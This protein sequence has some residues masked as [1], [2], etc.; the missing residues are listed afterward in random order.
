VLLDFGRVG[1]GGMGVLDWIWRSPAWAE[2]ALEEG[3]DEWKVYRG[4]L[5]LGFELRYPSTW[6]PTKKL[7]KTHSYELNLTGPSSNFVGLVVDPVK[8][9]SVEEFGTIQEVAERVLGLE[10]KKDG[11]TSAEL[12][13]TEVRVQNN[14]SGNPELSYYVLDYKVD[15]SRGKKRF[16]SVATITGQQLFVLTAQAKDNDYDSSSAVLHRIIDSFHVKKIFM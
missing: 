5:S 11:V 7:I 9:Q 1:L 3:D 13:S 16:L 12:V 8:I 2:E 4:P 15:S 10:R 6:E 14:A